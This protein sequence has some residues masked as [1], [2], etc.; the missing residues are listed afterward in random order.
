MNRPTTAREALIAEALGEVAL[1]VD[2]VEALTSSME[3]GRLALANA[4]AELSRGLNAFETRMASVT[5]QVQTKAIEHIVRRTGKATSD[6]IESQASAVQAAARLAFSGQVDSQVARLTKALQ[7]ANER[8]DRPWE[9]WLTYVAT[10]V[11]SAALTW[12]M[13]SSIALK[14]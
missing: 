5:Q 4:S 7:R 2:R 1:L 13:A 8:A 3:V 6:I 9:H 12:L 14:C 10:A 11:A